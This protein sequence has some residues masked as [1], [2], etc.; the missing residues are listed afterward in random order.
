M[1]NILKLSAAFLAISSMSSNALA[2]TAVGTANAR[3]VTPISVTAGTA[4]EFGSFA[5]SASTG[6]ITQAGVVTG[7]VTAVT[8]GATRAAG[9]FTVNGEAVNGTS[10]TF[11]LPATATLTSGANNM[12]ATLSLAAGTASRTLNASGV[13]AVSVNGS[14][15]VAASQAAGAYT[16]TYTVTVNY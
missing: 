14:L 7:G 16:G 4:L 1:K 12:T 6:T 3:V 15:A 5:S 9:T 8:G 11:T 2:A 13:D 10:Y